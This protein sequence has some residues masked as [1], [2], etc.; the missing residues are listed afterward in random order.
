MT[1][2]KRYLLSIPALLLLLG[3]SVA[4]AQYY[5]YDDA[6]R[7]LSVAYPD[8]AGIA[9]DYDEADNLL[10]AMPVNFP[11]APVDVQVSRLSPTSARVSW[12]PSAGVSQYVI[13]RRRADSAV[14]EEVATV[15]GG[16][17]VFIDPSLEGG[18][19]YAYRVS[20]I[21]PEGRSAPSAEAGFLGLPRPLIS[22][23]GVVNGASFSEEQPAAPGSIISIFGDNLGVELTDDGLQPF[24]ALAEGSPLPTELGGYRV[25]IGGIEAPLYFV[26]G[27]ATGN[28]GFAG[29]INAQ[30]PWE[31][32][33]GEVALKVLREGEDGVLE[34]E[35]VTIPLA[36]ISPAFFSFDFGSGRAVAVNLKI[37]GQSDVINGSVAQ[38]A[39]SLEGVTTQPAKLGGVVTLYANGL[40]PVEPPAATGDDS[41]DG[42]RGATIP[43]KVLV[44]PAEAEVLFAGL[45]PQFVGVYQINI[46]IPLA[47]VPGGAVPVVIEQG[48]V[49]SREDVTIAVRP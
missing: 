23:A 42:L 26:A 28:S 8:G 21:G 33:P 34:S 31:V 1:Y 14:W 44:G 30:V 38:P 19:D 5:V 2:A 10:A 40:G 20:A 25:T 22:E 41:L 46:V 24:T 37:D 36:R 48:G 43:V 18:A 11:A 49:R 3:A 32:Q 15:S 47:V 4:R 45:A 16:T 6:G 9:Y 27:Q 7:L 35:A 12:A 29:Q 13:E 17:S 39:G